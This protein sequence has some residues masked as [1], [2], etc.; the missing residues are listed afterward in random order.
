[1]LRTNG[2]DM[3]FLVDTGAAVSVIDSKLCNNVMIKQL[4]LAKRNLQCSSKFKISAASGNEFAIV[5]LYLMRME[6]PECS[7]DHQVFVVDGLRAG[8]IMGIDMLKSQEATIYCHKDR[9]AEV[10]FGSSRKEVAAVHVNN[11]NALYA[12]CRQTVPAGQAA[13]VNVRV[14]PPDGRA[15]PPAGTVLLCEGDQLMEMLATT[16][17]D[18]SVNV[19]VTCCEP[20]NMSPPGNSKKPLPNNGKMAATWVTS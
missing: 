20:P 7:F 8:A 14:Q 12:T 3:E 16:A 9:P 5:G 13:W 15:V 19:L 11:N 6:T 4:Y 10:T 1:M 2:K 18:G 17:D